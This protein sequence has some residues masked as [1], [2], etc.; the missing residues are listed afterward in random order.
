MS[1]SQVS[2]IIPAYNG[3]A[4]LA[5]TIQSVIAQ[6]YPNWELVIVDDCS[7][8]QTKAVVT[9]FTDPRV[10]YIVHEKNS[11]SNAAR[12][13]GIRASSGE[14]L[15]F[16]DQDDLFHPDKLKC[17]VAFLA[18]HPEVGATYNPRFELNHSGNTIRAIW[19]PPRQLSLSDLVLGFPVSPSEMV[20]R[21][22]W[23][24]RIGL[25]DESIFFYGGEYVLMGRLALT[26]C[27]FSSIDRVLNSRRYH[28]G[29]RIKDLHKACQA[30]LACQ[31]IIFDD[32]RYPTHIDELR[33]TAFANTYTIWAI[34]AFAQGDLKVGTFFV[35]KAIELNPTI[36]QGKP[37]LLVE[38]MVANSISDD[39][40]D[41][42]EFLYRMLSNMPPEYAWLL[43]TYDWC[44]IRGH[45]MKG[46][47]S[48]IWERVEEGKAHFARVKELGGQSD[49]TFE[50]YLSYQLS[51]YEEEFGFEAMKR[52]VR[53]LA[54][55]LEQIGTERSESTLLS[56]YWLCRA[57]ENYQT[58]EPT[59]VLRSIWQA[60]SAN[61]QCLKNR[62][63]LSIFFRSLPSALLGTRQLS[64][65]IP[66]ISHP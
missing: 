44:V 59:E 15:A 17:H 49:Y 50:Q 22:E 26:G 48:T 32:S 13:T 1:R 38:Q 25:W 43:Q 62:G 31:Q 11:G 21:R 35:H 40:I 33:N 9:Q 63:T 6:T 24:Y 60:V 28:A 4:F 5:E 65:H 45:L 34:A 57:F 27:T 14:I 46:V 12:N 55:S 41:H 2:V 10:K 51:S 58:G 52:V 64:Q 66:A 39:T 19:R 56:G 3:A 37:C 47:Q 7:T 23:L 16:L 61:P 8:D 42:E 53:D 18:Q 20:F 29:R 36:V 30:E 54:P